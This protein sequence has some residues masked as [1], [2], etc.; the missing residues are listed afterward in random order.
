VCRQAVPRKAGVPPDVSESIHIAEPGFWFGEL[1]LMSRGR[2]AVGAVA[3]TRA[4]ALCLGAAEF[5]AI[6]AA[7]PRFFAPL[8]AL[9][10]GRY[11]QAVAFLAE[12]QALGA[13]ARLRERLA[14]LVAM[15][16]AE[17]KGGGDVVLGASQ[18]ELARILGVSRQTI[19]PLLRQ[20]ARDGVIEVGFRKIRVIDARRLR[21]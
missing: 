14:D 7:E 20:L 11:A 3:Q 19:S 18:D 2:T 16:R 9:A 12:V 13:K 1:A 5:E 21:A 10:F 4:R 8:A 15:R 6:V 17:G